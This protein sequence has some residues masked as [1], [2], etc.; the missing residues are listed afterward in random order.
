MRINMTLEEIKVFLAEQKVCRLATIDKN[1][2]PHVVPIWYVI[3]DGEIYTETTGTTKKTKNIESNK[4]TA[5]VVDAGNSLYDYIGVMMQGEIE[6][7]SDKSIIERVR[8]AFAQRYF[9]S[10]EHPGYKFLTSMPNRVLLKFI[11]QKFV[12]WDHRKM[13][14]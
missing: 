2:V 12:S 8:E 1:G 6:L 13:K 4:K 9:G 5:L 11:P 10:N 7:V 3:L 14:S